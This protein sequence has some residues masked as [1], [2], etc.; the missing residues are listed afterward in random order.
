MVVATVPLLV[1]VPLVIETDGGVD[2]VSVHVQPPAEAFEH[3]AVSPVVDPAICVCRSAQVNVSG[4]RAPPS[5]VRHGAGRV[6][7]VVDVEVRSAVYVP[8]EVNVIVPV[9]C[10]LTMAVAVQ[11]IIVTV[12]VPLVTQAVDAVQVPT[13]SPPHAATAPHKAELLDEPPHERR[14]HAVKPKKNLPS[15]LER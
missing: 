5:T 8:V 12:W 13:R 9:I 7:V 2:G 10:G 1:Y 14:A 6:T 11:P 3:D 4:P 15:M